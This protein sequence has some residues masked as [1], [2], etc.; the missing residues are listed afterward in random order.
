MD[1]NNIG[2]QILQ[3][4]QQNPELA[5]AAAGGVGGAGLGALTGQNPL[6]TGLAGAGVGGGAGYAYGGRGG[7]EDSLGDDDL[8]QQLYQLYRPQQQSQG[9]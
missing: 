4:A 8:L 6:L 7:L 3:W 5:G 9:L 1:F 2:Q